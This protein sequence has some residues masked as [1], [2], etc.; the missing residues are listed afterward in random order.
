MVP[1]IGNREFRPTFWPSVVTI[2][3]FVLTAGL[4]AW[5]LQRAGEKRKL[6]ASYEAAQQRQ[7]LVSVSDGLLL[8]YPVFTP[9]QAE[10]RFDGGHQILLDA[11]QHEGR[12]G[13]LVLTPLRRADEPALLVNR[14]WL[15]ADADRNTLPDLSVSGEYRRVRGFLAQLP[16][17]ALRLSREPVSGSAPWPRVALYPDREQIEMMLG[18]PVLDFILLQAPDEADGFLRQWRPQI[19]P[20]ERHLG[21]AVQW[22]GL[23]LAL[24]VI[25]L[26][27]NLRRPEED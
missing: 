13:Y 14:G 22:F 21:Y 10:G 23:A 17:P 5:Q 15:A 20:P 1:R 18:Y 2:A 12:N 11:M 16:R 8:D 24:L 9:L 3:L 4:G 26:A 27:V 19:M 7:E 25:Y 6:F